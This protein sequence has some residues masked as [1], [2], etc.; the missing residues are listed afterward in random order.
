[1][2]Y[3]DEHDDNVTADSY[4]APRWVSTVFQQ[5]SVPVMIVELYRGCQAMCWVGSSS[6][7]IHSP[8]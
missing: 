1:V 4:R 7:S 3:Y 2:Y 6:V 8:A 5:P